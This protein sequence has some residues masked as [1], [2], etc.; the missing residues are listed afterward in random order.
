M[1]ITDELTPRNFITKIATYQHICS[2]PNTMT[3]LVNLT[4]TINLT[5]PELYHIIKI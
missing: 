2:I 1:P 3:I 5:N 4:G